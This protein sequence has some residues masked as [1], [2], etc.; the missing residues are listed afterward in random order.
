MA[1]QQG[2]PQIS[3]Q[4]VDEKRNITSAW[5][6]FLVSLWRRTGEGQGGTTFASGDMKAVAGPAMQD[7]W[8]LCN[9]ATLNQDDFPLLFM[10]IGTTWGMGGAGTFNLP[11]LRGRIPTGANIAS[12][13]GTYGGSATGF[14]TL[15]IGNLPSH[16]H[17]ITDV[18]HTHTFTGIAHNHALTDPQHTHVFTG[19]AH[20]HA[21]TDPL[22]HHASV[23][24][25]SVVT[26]GVNP[27][28]VT[29]GNTSDA[30]TGLSLANTI[31]GGT[32]ATAATGITLAATTAGGTNAS[33]FTGITTTQAVGSATPFDIRQPFAAVNWLIKS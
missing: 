4:F 24:A 16:S 8:L 15:T 14:V 22:H 28:G 17:P 12:P 10:A 2:F 18:Q 25:A 29:A 20:N 5:R 31:A 3:T 33:S 7:G 27:G 11:D 13:L 26:T 21:L 1:I 19:I 30:A 32:N 6:Q 9:G 23:I